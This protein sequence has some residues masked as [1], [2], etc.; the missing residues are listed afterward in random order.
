MTYRFLKPLG[1]AYLLLAFV[2]ALLVEI[3]KI[4]TTPILVGIAVI[5]GY[6]VFRSLRVSTLHTGPKWVNWAIL[7]GISGM[8]IIQLLLV[9]GVV[10]TTLPLLLFAGLLFFLWYLE[11]TYSTERDLGF[12]L[13]VLFV[14]TGLLNS[15]F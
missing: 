3:N 8:L 14:V 10:A 9:W 6:F 4:T 5:L 13:V 7:G 15:S 2:A 11:Y 12:F 1:I